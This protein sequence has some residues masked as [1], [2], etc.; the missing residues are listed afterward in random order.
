MCI[1]D[2]STQS[3]WGF[4]ILRNHTKILR[5]TMKQGSDIFFHSSSLDLKRLKTCLSKLREVFSENADLAP[6]AVQSIPKL[7]ED[8]QDVVD[9]ALKMK[10]GTLAL[11]YGIPGFGRK[12]AINQVLGA[13]EDKVVQINADATIFND[14]KKIMA[15]IIYELR[16]QEV[17]DENLDIKVLEGFKSFSSVDFDES[18]NCLVLVIDNFEEFANVKR[19]NILYSLLEWMQ[20]SQVPLLIFGVLSNIDFMEKL[21]KR[22]K[23]RLSATAHFLMSYNFDHLLQVLQKRVHCIKDQDGSKLLE[24]FINHEGILE[25]LRYHHKCQMS[26]RWFIKLYHLVFCCINEEEFYTVLKSSKKAREDYCLTTFIQSLDCLNPNYH[27]QI[28]KEL[29]LS[30]NLVLLTV[31]RM[32]VQEK[33]PL[34]LNTIKEDL[35]TLKKRSV[36]TLNF[37][38]DVLDQAFQNLLRLG[39]LALE[40]SESDKIENIECIL[41]IRIDDLTKMIKERSAEVPSALVEWSTSIQI[42]P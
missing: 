37:S 31:Q 7:Y 35:A 24:A 13:Y 28:A 34:T 6:E 16:K 25:I 19:Q 3:T 30:E 18:M 10:S 1:R 21:E 29:T 8:L 2:R 9:G 26:L 27:V 39:L 23:S 22:V 20:T 5:V 32:I 11:L 41:L 40:K 17:I 42:G 15:K 38:D 33:T 4:F 14:E 36:S 12:T